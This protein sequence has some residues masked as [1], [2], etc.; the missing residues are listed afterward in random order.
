V[1]YCTVQSGRQLSKFLR[2]ILNTLSGTPHVYTLKMKRVFC[3][4]VGNH[5]STWH[6]NLEYHNI[7]LLKTGLRLV[8]RGVNRL[9]TFLNEVLRVILRPKHKKSERRI[10]NIA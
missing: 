4:N 3:C 9:N 1:G 6:R 7:S 5:L 10:E 8:E 2:N